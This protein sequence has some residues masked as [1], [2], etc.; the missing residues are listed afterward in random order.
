[1]RGRGIG[2]DH[3]HTAIG[4]HSRLACAEV[5]AD[6]EGTTCAAFLARAAAFS[7]V[8]GIVPHRAGVDRQRPQPPGPAPF[9]QACADLGVRQKF[10]RL[11]CLWTNAL[12]GGRAG[13]LDGG[14]VAFWWAFGLSVL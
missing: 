10:T 5:L 2:Y 7:A 4:D 9:R 8:H 3:V 14:R 12:V 6:E 13:A 11:R 1:M